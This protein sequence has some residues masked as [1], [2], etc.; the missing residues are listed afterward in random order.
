MLRIKKRYWFLMTIISLALLAH[1]EFLKMRYSPQELL[2]SLTDKGIKQVALKKAKWE[3]HTQ[4]YL[5]ILGDTSRP[6]LIL[7]HGSPGSLTAFEPYYT[8]SFLLDHFDIVAVDRLGFGYSDFGIAE[9]SLALQANMLA[10]VLRQFSNKKKILVG[11]SMGG[12][13]LARMAMDYGKMVDGLV[14]VAPSV[15][16]ASEPSAGWRKAVN[17]IPLRWI[18]PPA[19]RVCN[20]EIIPL[21]G[22]LEAMLGGWENLPMPITVI[23]GTEDVLVPPEN[24]S[25][26]AEAVGDTTQVKITYVTGGDHFILWSEVPLI[27]EEIMAISAR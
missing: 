17:I 27:R 26:I 22:E 15:S 24:A 16:P 3:G 5:E 21:K 14:M 1:S 8:D 19:L 7:V 25:F 12:P 4:Q 2:L 9:P 11:H 13:L 10:E 23:Q 6:L 18:T 20:Q